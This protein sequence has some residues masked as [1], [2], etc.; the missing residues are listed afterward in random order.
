MAL[1]NN[2]FWILAGQ[3]NGEGGADL[4]T[5]TNQATYN[6]HGGGE[7]LEVRYCGDRNCLSNYPT[8]CLFIDDWKRVEANDP[9]ADKLFGPEISL[10]VDLEASSGIGTT[11][12]A[13][14]WIVK[15]TTGATNLA[16][17]WMPWSELP[18]RALYQ[19]MYE[20]YNTR[21]AEVEANPGTPGEIIYGGMLW[22]QGEADTGGDSAANAYEANLQ[23]FIDNVRTDF[24]VGTEP[25]AIMRLG[26]DQTDLDPTRKATVQA[27]QDAAETNNDGVYVIDM[28]SQSTAEGTHWNADGYIYLGSQAASIFSTHWGW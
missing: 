19:R 2:Y 28:D 25:F 5:A 24:G 3:S 7:V 16:N 26:A 20:T 12:D 21:V 11:E 27:A 9:T 14:H 18:S 22:C 23:N 4:D 10:S 1:R 13:N 17:H 8:A 15:C 6:V